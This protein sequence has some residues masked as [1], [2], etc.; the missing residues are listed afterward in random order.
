MEIVTPPRLPRSALLTLDLTIPGCLMR[1]KVSGPDQVSSFPEY[2]QIK[3]LDDEVMLH[4]PGVRLVVSV[5]R[6]TWSD[7]THISAASDCSIPL[8]SPWLPGLV[9]CACSAWQWARAAGTRSLT[10]GDICGMDRK[11]LRTGQIKPNCRA[12]CAHPSPAPDSCWVLDW[13]QKIWISYFSTK[14]PWARVQVWQTDNFHFSSFL[15]SPCKVFSLASIKLIPALSRPSCVSQTR[16]QS[17]ISCPAGGS[18]GRGGGSP[19]PGPDTPW[20]RPDTVCGPYSKPLNIQ[21]KI[22]PTCKGKWKKKALL[23]HWHWTSLSLGGRKG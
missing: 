10:P 17:P 20:H 18:G 2:L 6:P 5:V 14:F 9:L 4:T 16:V 8:S 15:G 21:Q 19:P 13:T 22:W 7:I 11:L 3:T 1:Q 23:G 12:A